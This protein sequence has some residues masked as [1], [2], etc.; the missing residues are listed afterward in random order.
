MQN[1]KQDIPTY[2]ALNNIRYI[3]QILPLSL[4]SDSAAKQDHKNQVYAKFGK[5]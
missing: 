1:K 2:I 4:A 5:T 3:L